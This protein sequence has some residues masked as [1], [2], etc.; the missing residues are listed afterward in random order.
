[1]PRV[2]SLK[3]CQFLAEMSVYDW[4]LC[5]YKSAAE[6]MILQG[7]VTLLAFIESIDIFEKALD[8]VAVRR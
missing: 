4:K 8:E 1:M 6:P 5:L 3:Y 2:I 7:A